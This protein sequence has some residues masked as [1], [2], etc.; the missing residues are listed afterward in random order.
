MYIFAT[1]RIP[2][3]STISS[4]KRQDYLLRPREVDDKA[5]FLARGGFTAANW[6]TLHAAIQE[7]AASTPAVQDGRNDYGIFWRTEGLLVGP[8]ANLRVALIWLEWAL[9]GTFHFVTLKPLR[10]SR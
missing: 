2:S 10:K 6:Q 1:I 4:A 3:T 7:L 5:R 9:D 8:Q